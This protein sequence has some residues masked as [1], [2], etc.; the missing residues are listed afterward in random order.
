MAPQ[1]A[2]GCLC[3]GVY[4][5]VC[6]TDSCRVINDTWEVLYITVNSGRL[7]IGGR[8]GRKVKALFECPGPLTVRQTSMIPTIKPTPH[9]LMSFSPFYQY[10]SDACAAIGVPANQV[11]ERRGGWR[12]LIGGWG[13]TSRTPNALGRQAGKQII[14]AAFCPLVVLSVLL[15]YPGIAC[16]SSSNQSI[17]L[18]EWQGNSGESRETRRGRGISL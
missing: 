1:Q 7:S 5:Q 18:P 16:L 11:E 17:W 13:R 4:T 14:L 9:P 3:L 12:G 8:L 15:F 2:E 10:V 6:R